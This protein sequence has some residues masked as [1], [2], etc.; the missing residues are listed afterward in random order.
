[1]AARGARPTAGQRAT[2]VSGLAAQRQHDCEHATASGGAGLPAGTGAHATRGCRPVQGLEQCGRER[3]CRTGGA[4][5]GSQHKE[6]WR[7]KKREKRV[8]ALKDSIS[9]FG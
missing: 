8:A 1:M 7:L 9:S 3:A 2:V 5:V 6:G 4:P